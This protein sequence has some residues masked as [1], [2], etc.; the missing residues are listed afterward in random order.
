M[1]GRRFRIAWSV[2]VAMVLAAPVFAQ[3]TL[4]VGTDQEDFAGT[5]PDRLGRFSVSGPVVGPGVII[6]L[7]YHL[8]MANSKICEHS[9]PVSRSL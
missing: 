1:N 6:P 2:I 7:P 9:L 4:F 3:G 8:C 5:L